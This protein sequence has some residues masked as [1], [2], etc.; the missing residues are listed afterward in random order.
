MDEL[1]IC[2]RI[3]HKMAAI[4]IVDADKPPFDQ[5]ETDERPRPAPKAR[6]ISDKAAVTKPPAI[7]AAQEAP[8]AF[9]SL[10]TE[11]SVAPV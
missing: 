8:D 6:R 9:A 7:I 5:S 10:L 3:S 11:V 4:P 2:I 1:M